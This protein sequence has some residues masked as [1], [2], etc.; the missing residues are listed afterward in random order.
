MYTIRGNP[1]LILLAVDFLL[2]MVVK[3]YK[4]VY[5]I[6]NFYSQFPVNLG[7]KVVVL[8]FNV[9]D[10]IPLRQPQKSICFLGL[11]KI[12]TRIKSLLKDVQT[13]TRH[14]HS[15]EIGNL[16]YIDYNLYFFI[17]NFKYSFAGYSGNKLVWLHYLR[18]RRI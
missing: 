9:Y 7:K 11:N 3:V 17:S 14:S 5:S 6:N 15:W 13:L 16:I 1:T 12:H 4:A 10:P 18:C 8:I 2:I